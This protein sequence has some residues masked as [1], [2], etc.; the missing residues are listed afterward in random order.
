LKVLVNRA[1]QDEHQLVPVWFELSLWARSREKLEDW[2]ASELKSKF[3][4]DG[5]KN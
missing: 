1:A 5:H 2:L 4:N 3:G